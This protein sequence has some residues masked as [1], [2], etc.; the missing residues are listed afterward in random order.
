MWVKNSYHGA[1]RFWNYVQD[2]SFIY[3]CCCNKCGNGRLFPVKCKCNDPNWA[4]KK[5]Y[6]ICG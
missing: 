5:A 2:K 6:H 3:T 1:A 4:W